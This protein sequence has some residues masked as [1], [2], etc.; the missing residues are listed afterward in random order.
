MLDLKIDLEN[1]DIKENDILKKY[2]KILEILLMDR[3]TSKNIL[4]MTDNYIKHGPRY[5]I[6]TEILVESIS[7][8]NGQ[9]IKPRIKK[10]KAE[11]VSRTKNKAEIFTPSWICNKQN[12]LIDNAWFGKQKIFNSEYGE[13]WVATKNK[14][15]FPNDKDK[16]WKN[17]VKLS[18]LE[19][20]CGE[21]PYLVSRY[22][23]KTGDFINISYRIG[24]LDRK[25]RVVSENTETMFDW[26]YWSKEAYKNIYGYE[27]QGDNLLLARENIL[28]TFF[29]YY[30]AKFNN[31]NLSYDYLIEIAEIISWN[32]WQMDGI[33]FV[34]PLSCHNNT[35]IEPDFFEPKKIVNIC[36]GC[37]TGD[38]KKH[39]GIY[40]KI[41][42]WEIN[43][44]VK[45]ISLL[46]GV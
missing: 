23:T 19:I 34:V 36:E 40:C 28:Y 14:I 39:N 42:D 33:K 17:Y 44:T 26:L 12:N 13:K 21:A 43:K 10:S 27:W 18:R 30:L 32:I 31:Y 41:M 22:D 37:K 1:I 15:N 7:G 9:I 4:W 2:P 8:Y 5:K 24:L 25:L 45:V 46:K 11:Q 20:S 6:E 3:T 38:I 35:I 16:S 29:D